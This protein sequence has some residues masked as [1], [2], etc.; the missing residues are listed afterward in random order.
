MRRAW[1]AVVAA[2]LMAGC[3][4]GD[5][6]GGQPKTVA[7]WQAE[8]GSTLVGLDSALDRA[9]AATRGGDP[10]GI[11]TNCE[12]LRDSVMEAQET[13]PVPDASVDQPL[14]SALDRLAKGAA[15][16]LRSVSQGDTPLLERS[17]VEIREARSAFD[18]AKARFPAS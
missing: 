12:G 2:T 18:T 13:P 9:Q 7:A 14:R 15:D 8:Y 4:G 16:C 3:G 5:G 6:G 11:R 17:I 1:A 10:V